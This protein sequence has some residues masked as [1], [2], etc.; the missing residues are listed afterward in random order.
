MLWNAEKIEQALSY[1]EG[2]QERLLD[3]VV[4]LINSYSD[5]ECDR[6]YVRIIAGSWL[7]HFSHHLFV[8]YDGQQPIEYCDNQKIASNDF[9]PA[10]GDVTDYKW[11]DP[12]IHNSIQSMLNH[13]SS[14]GEIEEKWM[15]DSVR[16]Y[17]KAGWK[18][19]ALKVVYWLLNP[20]EPKV[21]LVKPGVKGKLNLMRL[22]SK[23]GLRI[24]ISNMKY[25]CN[26]TFHLDKK[27]RVD[28]S[29][30]IVDINGYVDI[31]CKLLPL[32]IPAIFVE[33]FSEYRA[34]IKEKIPP[35]PKVVFSCNAL[36]NH[37][38]FCF[39][40]AEWRLNGTRLLY[41]QHGGGYG[42]EKCN[43]IENFESMSADTYYT[44][45][46]TNYK[47]NIVTMSPSWLTI[48]ENPDSDTVLLNC[49]DMPDE[50]YRIQFA[51]VGDL[52]NV[53]HQNTY[54]FLS[55]VGKSTPIKIRP[56]SY[57]Y[58]AGFLEGMIKVAPKA[59]IST[60]KS[61]MKDYSSSRLVVHNY[62]GTS[63]LETLSN[64]IPTICL[65]DPVDTHRFHENAQP[66]ID[67]LERVGILHCSGDS[68][69]QFLTEIYDNPYDWWKKPEVQ[70]AKNKFVAQY[71]NFSS[72][73][74]LQWENEFQKQIELV[75]QKI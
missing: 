8:A 59:I 67:E 63:W 71:A 69:G 7:I 15:A 42:I 55:A 19:T 10:F 33:G 62:I 30:E 29:K 2:C 60:C 58:H 54:D 20:S 41:M 3:E 34:W 46:W 24:A 50:L 52:R 6:E 4:E 61:N 35:R 57:D 28:R 9:I 14:G 12:S 18:T 5:A 74:I 23:K 43:S 32:Y 25:D 47:P 16:I 51:P 39:A 40:V 22:L 53:L 68:A 31:F 65:Y 45:G 1:L 38:E 75:S 11:I 13:V 44:Y 27:W 66:L 17:H 64:N 26:F 21:M 73:W 49:L 48:A 72:D 56:Y 37:S 36:H 70:S